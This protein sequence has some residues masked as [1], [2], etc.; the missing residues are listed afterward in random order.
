M[1]NNLKVD[2]LNQNSSRIEQVTFVEENSTIKEK[3]EWIIS[4]KWLM[5]NTQ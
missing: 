2:V 1:K 5:F 4:S 3:I